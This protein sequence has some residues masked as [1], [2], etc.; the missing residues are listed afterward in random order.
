MNLFFA[1]LPIAFLIFVMT[2]PRPM[3]SPIAFAIAAALAYLIRIFVFDSPFNLVNAAVIGGLLN[4]LTPIAIVFG[5]IFF[6]VA[7]ERSGAMNILREWLHDVSQN[8]VAQLMI[9]GWAFQFLIEGASGF[10]TPAALAAPIL[11]GLGFPALRVAILC[12]VMNSISV[13]FGAVGTPTWF[14]FGSLNLPT[15]QLV[16]LSFRTAVLQVVASLVIPLI[17]LRFVLNW[18][19]LRDSLGFI[20]LSV[21]SCVLPMLAVARFN[22]EFPTVVG[23][24]IGLIATIW[25]ARRG[26]GLGGASRRSTAPLFSRSLLL[27][28]LPLGAAVAILLITRIPFLGLRQWLTASTPNLEIPLGLLG[29]FSISPSLV[30]ELRQILGESLNWSHAI[31]YVPSIIPFLVTAVLALK[32]FKSTKLT[33]SVWDDTM[34]RIRKPVLALFGALVSVQLLMTGGESASTIILGSSLAALAGESWVYFAPFLGALGSFFSGS[35][36]ISNLTFGAIQQSIATETGVPAYQFLSLQSAGAAMGNMI[37]INNI[38][39]VCAVLGLVNQEGEILK[40]T[41]IPVIVYGAILA[42][43]SALS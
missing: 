37:A 35:A 20:L 25:L 9:V 12:L 28:L 8:S 33:R 5:A 11:V 14:G 3:P 18:H 27:A 29:D 19:H 24:T 22:D 23:G 30:V 13:S 41:I 40:R 43:V 15:D 6:F 2:K 7:M 26:I 21:L 10:G 42:L 39:A 36:T 16:S 17:A 32:L 1:A 31:L 38:V 34:G 4:A